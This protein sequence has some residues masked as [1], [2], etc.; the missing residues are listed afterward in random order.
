MQY[1]DDPAS[2]LNNGDLYYVTYGDINMPEIENALYETAAGDVCPQVFK[3]PTGF[4][5]LKVTEKKNRPYGVNVSHVLTLNQIDKNPADSAAAKKKIEDAIVDLNNGIPFPEVAKKYSDDKVTKEK[6]GFIGTIKRGEFPRALEEI[7]M[8]MKENEI[9]GIISAPYGYHIIK[10][11]KIVPYPSFEEQQEQLKQM[12]QQTGY[13]RD[14]QSFIANLKNQMGF[15]LNSGLYNKLI[16]V[17]DSMSVDDS[18]FNVKIRNKYKDSLFVT[19]NKKNYAADS[20][21]TFM[22]NNPELQSRK[23]DKNVLDEAADKYFSN[24]LVS[25]AAISR[26]TNEP[27]FE[28]IM[29]DYLMGIL[30]FKVSDIEIWSKIKI[31]S[32]QIKSYWEQTKEKYY[33]KPTVTYKEIFLNTPELRD[34]VFKALNDGASFDELL[35][36]SLKSTSQTARTKEPEKDKLAAVA[37]K[38]AKIG[39]YSDPIEYTGGWSIARLEGRNSPRMK[40]YEEARQEISSLLQEN[41]SKRIEEIYIKKLNEKFKPKIYPENILN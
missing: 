13:Q 21:F 38:I 14:L 33:T 34:S 4:H 20:I 1:T 39:D 17:K 24:V 6:G 15:K 32:N 22:A 27:E 11:D 35:K 5:I 36:K 12:Y 37:N 31:D 3:T 2:K 40:T 16:A 28:K 18:L 25:E 7:I 29:N 19:L 23:Y 26:L 8:N 30:L 41:E 9:S 10:V